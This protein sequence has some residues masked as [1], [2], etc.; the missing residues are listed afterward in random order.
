M[1]MHF[2]L[3][4][5]TLLSFS[6]CAPVEYALSNA[7][8][9]AAAEA[10]APTGLEPVTAQLQPAP[11]GLNRA[12]AKRYYAAQVALAKAAQVQKVKNSNN[13]TVEQKI[14]NISPAVLS[15][16]VALSL[17][18]GALIGYKIK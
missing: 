1:K 6:S 4:L 18:V 10:A 3:L 11:A 13:T 16:V 12:Q 2:V 5:A 17:S 15:L 9:Q 7:T 8:T 14:S